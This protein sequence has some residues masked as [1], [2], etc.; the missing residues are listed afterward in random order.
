MYKHINVSKH[1][2][3]YAYR[4]KAEGVQTMEEKKRKQQKCVER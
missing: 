3:T 4:L 2:H 1:T